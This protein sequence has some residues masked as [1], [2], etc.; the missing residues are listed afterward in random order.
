LILAG[1][2]DRYPSLQIILAHS[3]GALPILSSRL[4]SCIAH[5][6]VVCSRLEHDAR[7]YLGKLYYDAVCYGP[8]ELEYVAKIIGRSHRFQKGGSGAKRGD[9]SEAEEVQFGASR[10]MM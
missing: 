9:M 10:M 4:A 8:E 1:V 2:F 6:P 3:G 5:D 7:Y